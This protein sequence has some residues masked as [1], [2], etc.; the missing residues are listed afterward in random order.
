MSLPTP[1]ERAFVD[2]LLSLANPTSS[3]GRASLAALRRG[4]GKPPG[5]AAETYPIVAPYAPNESGWN[6][7][8]YYLVASLFASHPENWRGQD[9]DWET[10][11]GASLRRARRESGGIEAL[12]IALLNSARD[13]LP[14]RLRHGVALCAA[15][16][17]APVS[18]DWAQLLQDLRW[19]DSERREIQRRW[20]ASFWQPESDE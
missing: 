17:P 19:W 14:E 4:L 13:E 10:N 5:T 15:A 2:H 1:R 11:L 20:A 9:S 6:A 12:F 8:R 16:A 18:I 3:T 7:D